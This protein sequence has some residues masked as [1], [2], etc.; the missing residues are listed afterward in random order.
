MPQK[1]NPDDLEL[2]RGKAGR[3]FGH[4]A[5]VYCATKGLPSTYNKDLQENWEPMLDHVKTVSDS[6]QIANGILSTLKLRPE[7]MIASLNPFLLATD[8]ADALV[9]IVVPFRETPYF[10]ACGGQ[11]QGAGNPNGPTEPGAA[12]GH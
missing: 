10:R 4:L 2:L 6:V 1:K 12:A 7:R 5:G 8:V 9:K 3:T 11:E